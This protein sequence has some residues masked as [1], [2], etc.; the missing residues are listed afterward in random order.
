MKVEHVI[1]LSVVEKEHGSTVGTVRGLL[2]DA[3][4]KKVTALTIDEANRRRK[5]YLPFA[6]VVSIEHDAVMI[7]SAGTLTDRGRYRDT[8]ILDSLYGRTVLTEDGRELGKIIGYDVEPADGS[9]LSIRFG[10]DVPVLGGLWR[11]S[12][13]V[14]EVSGDVI[15][16]IG[17]HVLVDNSVP[18]EIGIRPAA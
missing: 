1:G 9:I 10:S 13:E 7:P 3:D 11:K 17:E 12:G 6:D 14:H 2:V 15:K 16:T 8:G 18:E 5:R 4:A